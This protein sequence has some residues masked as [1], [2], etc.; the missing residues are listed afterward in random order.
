ML[1]LNPAPPQLSVPMPSTRQ[2]INPFRALQKHRNFRIFWAGQT[3]SQIGAWMQSMAQGW[4][5][6][7]LSNSPLVVGLVSF[8]GSLPIVLLSLQAGV[9]S[10]RYHRLRIVKIAQSLLLVE[11]VLLWWFTWS[12]NITIGWL[13]LLATITGILGA[14]EIPARQSLM[15]DLVGREDLREAIALNSSGF[16]LARIVGPWLGALV[17]GSF[18]L[19]WC[20]ALNALSFVAVLVGLFLIRLPPWIPVAASV[21]TGEGIRELWRYIRATREV[22]VVMRLV[23]VYSILGIPYLTLMPVVARDVLRIG[24]KGY[25]MLLGCVGIGGLSGALFLASVGTRLPRGRLLAATSHSFAILLILFSLVRI[26]ILAY[27]ALLATGFAMILNNALSNGILQSIVPD[28]MRGRLMAAYS[29]AVVGLSQV[30][31]AIVAGAIASA[32]G[33]PWA[34]GGAAAAM[35]AYAVFVFARYPEARAM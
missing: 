7:E 9:L 21:S 34:I 23:A 6:L 27:P 12:G 16:N 26:P 1:A 18:G 14:V 8:A 11:A 17:I 31:G 4:L 35:L 2:S 28:A 3:V 10:D 15:I 25:G 19:A 13:L 33:A 30:V 20:F 5:A 32:F 22:S 24:P 29:I